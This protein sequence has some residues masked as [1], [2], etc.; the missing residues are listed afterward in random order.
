MN[1]KRIRFDNISLIKTALVILSCLVV[2]A[3]NNQEIN[4]NPDNPLPAVAPRITEADSLKILFDSL[5]QV[6]V[7]IPQVID[8]KVVDSTCHRQFLE[9][10]EKTGGDLKIMVNARFVSKT[11]KDI[12]ESNSCDSAD[13][14]F[15]IDKTGSMED[16]IDNIKRGLNNV[17]ESLKKFN[18]NRLA[19][20]CYGDRNVDG[21]DWFTYHN[22]GNNFM[23]ARGFI[24]SIQVTGGDDFPESVN[25]AFFEVLKKDFWR[26]G[27]KRMIILIGDAP[28]LLPPLSKHTLREVIEK[29]KEDKISM[30]FYPILISPY[31]K[32]ELGMVRRME[33]IKMIQTIYPNPTN[34]LLNIEFIKE[35]NYTVDILD[36]EGKLLSSEVVKGSNYKKD[37]SEYANGLYIIRVT[38]YYK[39]FDN[40]KIVL[41]K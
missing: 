15:L 40:G 25:D 38:D 9:L 27:T 26:S 7:E 11:I 33:E 1:P 36:H 32:E 22:F 30:N 18:G 14:L 39:N 17:I 37:L 3:C 23:G 5:M 20:A 19:I 41:Q 12:I 8:K 29:A 35:K 24:N 2:A 6:K 4:N 28:S 31:E 13:V 10:A 16:D 34:G 21:D